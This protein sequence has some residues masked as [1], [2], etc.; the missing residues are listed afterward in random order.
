MRV[1]LEYCFDHSSS[2]KLYGEVA[3]SLRRRGIEA[4]LLQFADGM[5]VSS[6][7]LLV[8]HDYVDQRGIDEEAT[9][10]YG[11]R[12]MTRPEE[13]AAIAAA[14]VPVMP[15][16]LAANQAEVID[17]FGRWRA[18]RLLLKRSGT[19]KGEGVTVFDRRHAAGLSWDS[20][21][22]LFCPELND[23]DGD[24]YKIEIFNGR[25]IL[26]WV[27]RSPPLARS[28]DGFIVG[29]KGAFGRRRLIGY[30]RALRGAAC[31][32]SRALTDRGI[33]YVS[34]DL[35]KD[36]AGNLLAIELNTAQVATWWTA[37]FPWMRW[38]YARAVVELVEAARRTDSTEHA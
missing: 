32:L 36:T 20:H 24:V 31:N 17:L 18:E 10:V 29:V 8:S 2:Y 26:G 3:T 38:R 5:D 34:L 4:T 25:T 19:F 13:M 33:G 12:Y 35:M 23:T 6:Y 15:W 37:R 1:L 16:A 28:F 14:G 30:P 27:S 11:G 21:R 9:R 7:D 22:D